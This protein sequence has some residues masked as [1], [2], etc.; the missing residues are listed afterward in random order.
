MSADALENLKG[1]LVSTAQPTT[2]NQDGWILQLHMINNDKSLMGKTS[3][4]RIS[5][6]EEISFFFG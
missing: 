5:I 4:K 6:N 1:F 2:M 3:K